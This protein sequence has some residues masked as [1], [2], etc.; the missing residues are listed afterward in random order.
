[1]IFF[2]VEEPDYNMKLM[3]TCGGMTVKNGQKESKNSYEDNSGSIKKTMSKY[4]KPFFNHFLYR[5]V[6]DDHNNCCHASPS[7]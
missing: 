5:H 2:C 4:A 3:Y 7:I 1:M 6:V